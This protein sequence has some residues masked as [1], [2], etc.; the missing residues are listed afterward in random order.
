MQTVDGYIV[1]FDKDGKWEVW[2]EHP[3][4]PHKD[5]NP[6]DAR[7]VAYNEAHK[8]YLQIKRV[9]CTTSARILEFRQTQYP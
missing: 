4:I 9:S 5:S 6:S 8:E 1:L 2:S 3:V 7:T